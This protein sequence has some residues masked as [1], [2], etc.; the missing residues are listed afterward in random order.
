M[1][2]PTSLLLSFSPHVESKSKASYKSAEKITQKECNTRSSTKARDSLSLT[3]EIE[4]PLAQLPLPSLSLFFLLHPNGPDYF[5]LLPSY[6]IAGGLEK[7]D[8]RPLKNKTHT[9]ATVATIS[10]LKKKN[11]H[12]NSFLF[13]HNCDSRL[14]LCANGEIP[15][16]FAFRVSQNSSR[17]AL[18]SPSAVPYFLMVIQ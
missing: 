2:P 13:K 18:D 16:D 3:H 5:G 11:I 7:K 15:E 4:L 1:S 6:C 8:S 14:S 12:H 10:I 9:T 17:M